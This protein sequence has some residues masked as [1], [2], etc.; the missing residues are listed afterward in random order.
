MQGLYDC[1][2]DVFQSIDTEESE[3]KKVTTDLFLKWRNGDICGFFIQN[4]KKHNLDMVSKLF[5]EFNFK[6]A[7]E[8]LS[9]NTVIKA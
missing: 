1:E 4:F 3:L 8:T 7:K 5:P 9:K 6:A 2:E